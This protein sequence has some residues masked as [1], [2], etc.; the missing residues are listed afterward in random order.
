MRKVAIWGQ[1][2]EIATSQNIRSPVLCLCRSAN[3]N[4]ISISISVRW[5]PSSTI[6]IVVAESWYRGILLILHLH[7]VLSPGQTIATCQCNISQHC[8]AQHV[9]RVWPP[10]CIMLGVVGSN[11][12]IFKLEQHPTCRNTK[13]ARNR[14]RPTM[15]R[16][17]ALTCCDRLAGALC[18]CSGVLTYFLILLML[19][20]VR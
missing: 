14:L 1:L 10:C 20:L 19:V 17:V 13:N 11:L 4:E 6:L 15:L 7:M 9:A 8:W 12:T 3:M 2:C 18:L 16:Y 5:S